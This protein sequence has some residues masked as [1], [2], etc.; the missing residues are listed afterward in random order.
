MQPDNATA[1]MALAVSYTN[2]SLQNQVCRTLT[3]LGDLLLVPR[4]SD[5]FARARFLKLAKHTR[6]GINQRFSPLYSA[7]KDK[8]QIE[9][10][11][12]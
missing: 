11:K 5:R 9:E 8:V 10:Q 3:V 1:R 2:E 6:E 4:K 7:G 12:H